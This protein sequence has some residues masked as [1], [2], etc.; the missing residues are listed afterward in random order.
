MAVLALLGRCSSRVGALARRGVRDSRPGLPFL[1]YSLLLKTASNSASGS[2][3][4]PPV[5]TALDVLQL[6]KHDAPRFVGEHD[7]LSEAIQRMDD[8]RISSLVVRDAQDRVVGFITQLDILRAIVRIGV[9]DEYSGEPTGWNVPVAQVMTPSKDLVFLSPT[10]T[11]ED[12][13]SLMAI[14]GKRHIP[15]L[16]G[17]TLLGILNP[18]DIAKYIHLSTERSAKAEYV[19]TV[20]PRKGMPL[21]TKVK[22]EGPAAGVPGVHVQLHSAVCLLPHPRKV[23]TGGEDAYLLGPH[24][25]GVADGVG[26][27]ALPR[28]AMLSP[29]CSQMA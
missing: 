10:D 7:L 5:V 4:Q 14:S 22:A 3:K 9:K 19:T 2:P 13:R 29:S 12:A 21:G 26:A 15:V 6:T 16:S 1:P 24:M 25:I 18:K 17:S 27:L 20:M 8:N 23:E 28:S 11:L